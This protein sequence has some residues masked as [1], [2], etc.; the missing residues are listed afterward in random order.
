[1]LISAV[2]SR[3]S[4]DQVAVILLERQFEESLA[5]PRVHG[6]GPGRGTPTEGRGLADAIQEIVTKVR[7]DGQDAVPLALVTV[8]RLRRP[9][10]ADAVAV[11]P[12]ASRALFAE[13]DRDLAT[14][15]AGVVAATP[16]PV[17]G[18]ESA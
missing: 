9:L 6:T 4:P 18:E 14:P 10:V 12:S 11:R 1:M 8:P 3:A 15:I 2:R 16:Q 17:A 5:R 13:L 7:E